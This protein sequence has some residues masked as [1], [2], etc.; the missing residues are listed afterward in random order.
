MCA[1][2]NKIGMHKTLICTTR[3]TF[4]ILRRPIAVSEL[5]TVVEL[6]QEGQFI[7]AFWFPK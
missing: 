4:N 6:I 2:T 1:G 5:Y 3:S 7:Y